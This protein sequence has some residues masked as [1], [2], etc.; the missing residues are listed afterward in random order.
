LPIIDGR[1]TTGLLE[2][3]NTG[4]MDSGKKENICRTFT[5]YSNGFP[6]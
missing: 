3:W 4:M 2:N 1:E 5:H 6:R